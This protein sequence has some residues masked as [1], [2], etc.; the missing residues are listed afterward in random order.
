MFL[1]KEVR[2][3]SVIHRMRQGLPGT[4]IRCDVFSLDERCRNEIY[5]AECVSEGRAAPLTHPPSPNLKNNGL[6]NLEFGEGRERLAPYPLFLSSSH[7]K[8]LNT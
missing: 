1:E 6:E 7:I 3:L 2:N 4:M 5:E 8:V